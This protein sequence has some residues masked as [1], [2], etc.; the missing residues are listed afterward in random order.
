MDK[1]TDVQRAM[2]TSMEMLAKSIDAFDTG[3]AEFAKTLG[4]DPVLLDRLQRYCDACRRMATGTL[5]FT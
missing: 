1:D 4:D 2:D 3:V 5:Y